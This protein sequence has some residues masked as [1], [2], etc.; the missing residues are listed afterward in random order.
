M[1][2]GNHIVALLDGKF[3]IFILLLRGCYLKIN[4]G[5][6]GSTP[7]KRIFRRFH[8]RQI[9]IK[10]STA[11]CPPPKAKMP[12]HG[13]APDHCNGICFTGDNTPAKEGGD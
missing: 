11:R 1:T 7:P 12:P 3:F 8:L 13:R 4:H 10:F 9:T 2:N 5:G 6:L